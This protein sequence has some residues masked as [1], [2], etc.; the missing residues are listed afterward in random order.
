MVEGLPN[1]LVRKVDRSPCALPYQARLIPISFPSKH[2]SSKAAVPGPA[3]TPALSITSAC[4][5]PPGAPTPPHWQ[6][7]HRGP[8]EPCREVLM[9][10][11]APGS[12][13][14]RWLRRRVRTLLWSYPVVLGQADGSEE[15]NLERSITFG[16]SP[17]VYASHQSEFLPCFVW[18]IP[19][20]NKQKILAISN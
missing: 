16:F 11:R 9:L 3:S 12:C 4:P 13:H 8:R 20:E 7:L 17:E 10:I 5:S 2:C 14:T 19:T 18:K 6:R 15:N 1:Y